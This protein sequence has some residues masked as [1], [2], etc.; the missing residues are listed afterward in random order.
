MNPSSGFIKEECSIEIPNEGQLALTADFDHPVIHVIEG[1]DCGVKI[2]VTSEDVSGEW[3]LIGR[4]R[5]F[6]EAIERRLSFTINIEGIISF[7]LLDYVNYSK[8]YAYPVTSI[9]KIKT[10]FRDR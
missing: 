5:F 10:S 9:D 3:V 1:S 2:H 8:S 6:N 4:Y 7:V